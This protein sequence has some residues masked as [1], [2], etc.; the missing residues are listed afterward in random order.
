MPGCSNPNGTGTQVLA[1]ER[2]MPA[3]LSFD[4]ELE[5]E[6]SQEDPS[7]RSTVQALA[8]QVSQM[9][10]VL[11]NLVK[12]KSPA[13]NVPFEG[14]SNIPPSILA[15]GTLPPPPPTPLPHPV[16]LP[17]LTTVDQNLPSSSR[18]S[19]PDFPTSM[20]KDGKS[21]SLTQTAVAFSSGLLPGDL[22][23]ERIR[24]KI[25]DDQYIDLYELLY[26][27]PDSYT[28]SVSLDSNIKFNLPKKKRNL[29]PQEWSRAFDLYQ[30]C[31][32]KKYEASNNDKLALKVGQELLAYSRLI[33]KFMHEGLDWQYYDKTF[34]KEREI[35]KASFASLRMDLHASAFT[36][37]HQYGMQANGSAPNRYNKEKFRSSEN[38]DDGNQSLPLGYCFAY[39]DRSQTCNRK[40]CSTVHTIMN[41]FDAITTILLT[42]PTDVVLSTSLIQKI[43][44]TTIATNYTITTDN[45]TVTNRTTMINPTTYYTS[46]LPTPLNTDVINTLLGKYADKDYIDNGFQVGFNIG[47][48]GNES[49]VFSTNS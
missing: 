13:D 26:P 38:K 12:D 11:L 41:V 2:T 18:I 32:I 22:L 21:I 20:E 17:G 30:A 9:S 46:T 19:G 6:F 24:T 27:D 3:A 14:F 7:L 28:L 45:T 34:R 31:Y 39:H 33:N 47:F 8:T 15:A 43:I 48:S 42:K 1:A 16:T 36:R 23:P 44:K 35:S 49:Y 4:S 29:N 5:S 37:A 40:R 25:W 10:K